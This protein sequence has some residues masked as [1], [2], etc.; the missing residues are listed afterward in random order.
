MKKYYL[1]FASV[2]QISLFGV[3][4][5]QAQQAK[6]ENIS[7]SLT[8]SSGVEA[9]PQQP[10]S[11]NAV[12]VESDASDPVFS[13]LYEKG[14]TYEMFKPEQE[15]LS[16]RGESAKHF[17]LPDGSYSAI[18]TSGPA[19]Y[20][21][22]GGWRTMSGA[23]L[24]AR[25]AQY[26]FAN[27]HNATKTHYG[28]TIAE[29]VKM[30]RPEGAV[31]NNFAPKSVLALDAGGSVISQLFDADRSSP[32]Q[33][34]EQKFNVVSYPDVFPYTRLD[35]RQQLGAIKTSY[36]ITQNIF[37]GIPSHA[38]K[39]AF[40]EKVEIPAGAT[41]E[42]LDERADGKGVSIV[43]KKG[44]EIILTYRDAYFFDDTANH[45]RRKGGIA[46]LNYTLSGNELQFQVLVPAA[47]LRDSA[48]QYPVTVDPTIN[49]NIAAWWTG[50]VGDCGLYNNYVDFGFYDDNAFWS[51]LF[52]GSNADLN[53]WMTFDISTVPATT[54][55]TNNAYVQY[56]QEGLN[57]GDYMNFDFG[58]CG[59]NPVD[60]YSGCTI[61]DYTNGLWERYTRWYTKYC[62][63]EN[64]CANNCC[65]GQDYNEYYYG[66]GYWHDMIY[67][68]NP[69]LWSP[70]N[71][72]ANNNTFANRLITQRQ[73]GATKMTLAMD[74]WAHDDDCFWCWGDESL[75]IYGYGYLGSDGAGSYRPRLIY[76]YSYL[77]TG[78]TLPTAIS[79]GSLSCSNPTYGPNTQNNSTSNCFG[80]EVQNA[81]HDIW[82]TFT[83]ANPATINVSTCGSGFD[84]WLGIYNAASTL[85]YYND[86]NGNGVVSGCS[87]ASYEASIQVTLAAGTYYVAVEGFGS[88]TGN[89][90]TRIQ[91]PASSSYGTLSNTGPI[92]FCGTGSPTYC[93]GAPTVTITGYGGNPV[94]YYGSSDGTW[95][96]S[97]T[98]ATGATSCSSCFPPKVSN[99]DANYDRVRVTVTNA[100]CTPATSP[101]VLLRNRFNAAPSGPLTGTVSGQVCQSGFYL[102]ATF[103]DPTNILGNVEFMRDFCGGTV[104]SSV[105]GNG[106]T[107]VTSGLITVPTSGTYTY[108]ARY[109]PGVYTGCSPTGCTPGAT[110]TIVPN[111][112]PPTSAQ[113][114]AAPVSG[115]TVCGGNT[116]QITS[117]GGGT[118]IGVDCGFELQY[119]TDNGSTW[120]ASYIAPGSKATSG[121]AGTTTIFVRTGLPITNGMG[122]S[123][124][125]IAA[126]TT[127]TAYN[128]STGQVT[129]SIA[130][131]A[132]VVGNLIMFGFPYSFTAVGP[133]TNMVRARRANCGSSC[134]ASSW[135]TIASWSVIAAP[136][137][138]TTATPS[139]NL[140]NVCLGSTLTLA[141]AATGGNAGLACQIIYEYSIAGGSWISN[142]TTIPSMSTGSAGVYSIRAYR[143]NCSGGCSNTTPNV[144]ATWTAVADPTSPTTA[145][146]SPNLSSVCAGTQLTLTGA[147]TGGNAGVGC[148]IEYQYTT[149]GGGAWTN[150]GTVVPSFAAVNSGSANM[151]QGRRSNCT[152]GAGCTD[153][154]TPWNT[155]ASWTVVSGPT[156]GTLAAT[157]TP[158]SSFACAPVTLQLNSMSDPQNTYG[159]SIQYQWS[160]DGGATY[161]SP[162]T[163]SSFPYTAISNAG[164]G[165]Y[166]L[167]ARR[168]NC[169]SCNGITQA[170]QTIAD[171]T[172]VAVPDGVN[173]TQ[174]IVVDFASLNCK[175]FLDT[176][177]N[178]TDRCYLDDYTGSNNQST[179]DV[180]Y[181]FTLS[182]AATVEISTCGSST[183]TYIHLH[184]DNSGTLG[185]LITENNDAGSGTPCAFSA[186]SYISQSL[187]A[188]TYWAVVEVVSGFSAGDIYVSLGLDIPTG[189]LSGATSVCYYAGGYGSI[190]YTVN[191]SN[192][193]APYI[194]EYK[195]VVLSGQTSANETVN[196]GAS[197]TSDTV[198]VKKSFYGGSCQVEVGRLPVTI[199]NQLFSLTGGNCSGATAID[200]ITLSGSEVGVTYELLLNNGSIGG[201]GGCTIAGT[202]SALSFP[203]QT[204]SGT[205]TVR[206]TLNS[207]GAC[208]H[209]LHGSISST[210]PTVYT[211]SGTTSICQGE[212]TVLSLNGSESGTVY[213]LT[214]SGGSVASVV[215]GTGSG[216]SFDAVSP[217]ADETYTAYALNS[218]TGCRSAMSP[219]RT[220]TVST[221]P[222][223]LPVGPDPGTCGGNIT[224][225]VGSA[226]SPTQT[227]VTYQRYASTDGGASYSPVSTTIAGDGTGPKSWTALT[228]AGGLFKVYATRGACVTIMDD[229]T[230]L[231][232]ALTSSRTAKA[233]VA[234]SIS[235]AT[236][237]TITV[238]STD[239]ITVGML[240]LSPTSVDATLYGSGSGIATNTVVTAVNTSTKVVTLS[241]STNS[242]A[243]GNVTFRGTVAELCAGA[244]IS[245]NLVG[246]GSTYTSQN[247]QQNVTYTL[248]DSASGTTIASMTPSN[249][250]TP[251]SFTNVT[252]TANSDYYIYADGAGCSTVY[253]S[254]GNS[255]SAQTKT[256]TAGNAGVFT[257][258]VSASTGVL[259]GMLVTGTNVGTNA[260]VRIVGTTMTLTVVNAGSVASQTLTYTPV[261]AKVNILKPANQNVT[262]TSPQAYCYTGSGV[263]SPGLSAVEAGATYK[264]FMNGSD[265]G[266]GA[267]STTNPSAWNNRSASG[268]YTVVATTTSTGC[269]ATMTDSV[270]IKPA[271]TVY[272]TS[273]S[274][275]NVCYG[276]T[277]TITLSGSQTGVNYQL[278]R[279]GANVSG[280]VISGTGSSL[281]F[282]AQSDA[283]VYTVVATDAV[284]TSATGSSGVN[285]LTVASTADIMRGMTVSG[286]GV[287]GTVTNVNNTTKVVTLSANNTA[288]LSGDQVT[289]SAG[290]SANMTGTVTIMDLVNQTVNVVET[291]GAA[292]N[293]GIICAG[294]TFS[295]TMSASESGVNYQLYNVTSSSNV[296]SAQAGTGSGTFAP[297]A[298]T[299]LTTAA[300]YKVIGTWATAPN[301]TEDMAN[302]IT[303]TSHA[304]PT[305]VTVSCASPADAI[306][307]DGSGVSGATT[308]TVNSNTGISTGM[309]V[310]GGDVGTNATVT[311]I[312]GTTITLSVANNADF[313]GNSNLTFTPACVSS[314]SCGSA[315]L[316]ATGGTPGRIYWQNTTNGGTSTATLSSA[317]TVTSS[318]TY[319]FRAENNGCWGTQGS[320]PVTINA[321]P[322]TPTVVDFS[323]LNITTTGASGDGTTATLTFANPGYVPFDVGTR[324]QVTGV[325]PAG[326][327][328]NYT[329]TASSATSVSYLNATTGAQTG[330][331]TIKGLVCG[332]AVLIATNGNSGTMYFQENISGGTDEG[333]GGSPQT[334]SS[335]STYYFR[336]KGSNGCWSDEGSLPVTLSSLSVSA[337]KSNCINV[338]GT[339]DNEYMLVSASGGTAPYTFSSSGSAAI[340][341][342]PTSSVTVDATGTS[343]Q[344]TIDVSSTSG[345][346]TGMIATGTGIGTNAAITSIS[347]ATITLSVANTANIS[348]TANVTFTRTSKVF[349]RPLPSS[350]NENEAFIITDTK[351]CEAQVSATFTVGHPDNIPYEF[352]SGD[353]IKV[354]CYTNAFNRWLTFRDPVTTTNA[355]LTIND[356]GANLGIVSAT[357]Y[358]DAA[359]TDAALNATCAGYYQKA[360]KRHYV[361]T[362]QSQPTGGTLVGVRLYFSD[363]ELSDLISATAANNGGNAFCSGV[364]DVTS[365]NDLFVTK[366]TGT[367]EDGRY[368][369]N[370]ASGLY[371]LY[372]QSLSSGPTK[373]TS[374]SNGF[375]TLFSGAVSP[376]KHYV[377][378]TAAE[379]SE[380]WLHGSSVAAPLPVE[381][382]YLEA[383]AINNAYIQV[384]WATAI[385]I[386]NDYFEV[387]RSTDGQNW[388]VLGN[389][390]GNDNSTIR[391]DY[392]YNDMNVVAGVRYYYR[393]RQV[394][395][396]GE[397]EFTSIVSAMI[398]GEVTFSVKDFVPNPTMDKTALVVVATK[399]Q[400]IK[401]DFYNIIGQLVMGGVYQLNHGGNR[402]EFEMGHLAAGTYTAVVSSA[403][404]IYTKK[405]VL[406]K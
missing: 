368:D 291:S 123:G 156:Y 36:T 311:A 392:S 240:V 159:C 390:N 359:E 243:T 406:T 251:I 49:T 55:C 92:D 81:S 50:T 93:A 182:S 360:M 122:V 327:N 198:V 323:S 5:L 91:T 60:G 163:V 113:T 89:I 135:A 165:R 115:S 141:G 402:L 325:T 259:T 61:R 397:F 232:P 134:T 335:S 293:D 301:C 13:R 300:T 329:V 62:Y 272:T 71:Y 9:V 236:A 170:W 148:S 404:E 72:W 224:I 168:Y 52:G 218:T 322:T 317:Q 30:I 138:P 75:I 179:D 186:Q 357:L 217:S 308:I 386:N 279:N 372:D 188:G 15:D 351:G 35:V 344:Y 248:R 297:A 342:S 172:V 40:V 384:R 191:S 393:L 255:G 295:I 97:P 47:W 76:N 196:F 11:E 82:Y 167:Q 147:A 126:N 194:W 27:T 88:L 216:I 253:G 260:W 373:L 304:V 400:E 239:G 152:S 283:G 340:I 119:S 220:V 132:S 45:H 33:T 241:T 298:W 306:I 177:N 321:K 78:A 324:I 95:Y 19:H 265:L 314:T 242:S 313:S 353:S 213:Q 149:N 229:S 145:T 34:N 355:L 367:M 339:G 146:P 136:T 247:G 257:H 120:S 125:G 347:G 23:I 285:T 290:C 94:W 46:D 56:C 331:G 389:V 180:F 245:I 109:N 105:A 108:Y 396:D 157:I 281:N 337:T 269:T 153:P 246:N 369:N 263:V 111:P 200:D 401:V 1:I 103:D 267:Q 202:G 391:H 350:G 226:G 14:G 43:V 394:D 150:T 201:C 129:L 212:S 102:I 192:S 332:T 18:I 130:T 341:A 208:N 334:V 26:P 315:T 268:V 254:S 287:S 64:D 237:S 271:I 371:R 365:I 352:A 41:V 96:S 250:T 140:S 38:D 358:R 110:V 276:S 112:D 261:G 303:V 275:A 258:S 162:F 289:F 77:P 70:A 398:N 181:K 7:G 66:P 22:N 383:E 32:V 305:A 214:T 377:E 277:T 264:L 48:I 270:V 37:N 207:N 381:M 387:Q 57:N 273:G 144:L 348:G 296:G 330:A 42:R 286:T 284:T 171:W 73:G 378:L 405:L 117:T 223:Q 356:N 17:R 24:P 154:T 63:G 28:A 319:Y 189:S 114:A 8:A 215:V 318:G 299:G 244:S 116:L 288:P 193:S 292:N 316:F 206:G 187:S 345:L 139:P 227:G 3:C 155:L 121:G 205:Y 235:A 44:N 178:S 185:S 310:T 86:D 399:D 79:A 184:N 328:G 83:L 169:T 87:P 262:P 4:N 183:D 380:F 175:A 106:T 31:L 84:T 266:L 343:G 67:N 21:E 336:A 69:A 346:A 222:N 403:N 127:V 338:T 395:N 16:K 210:W 349:E 225:S 101:A 195:D 209:T 51:W 65:Q 211:L 375:A 238:A 233:V 204:G 362:A 151:I 190:A 29:G 137:S 374:A 142:G 90:V 199:F 74:M 231:T 104:V 164:A 252:P 249:G 53:A 221:P 25:D 133:Q 312:S 158:N 309:L 364:D 320:F 85:L 370:S 2:F 173:T 385:E 197:G 203:S 274:P 58:W 376:A 282:G 54:T 124:T 234:T 160:T 98:C 379:L 326:Y 68:T 361:I 174:P 307:K 143:G 12:P 228:H 333:L 382:I 6:H 118:N 230:E 131:T 280:A 354:S 128:S 363:Q 39:L 294:S 302:T 59:I 100:N 161:G 166:I 107:T 278:K 256:P 388:T 176:V 20:W 219:S 80:N 10:A 366:Y 99:S